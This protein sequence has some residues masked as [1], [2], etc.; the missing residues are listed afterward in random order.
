MKHKKKSGFFTFLC[1]FLPGAAEMYMGFMKTGLSLIFLFFA[2][3]ALP[4]LFGGS[5]IFLGLAFIVWIFSFFHARNLWALSDEDFAEMTDDYVWS[6]CDIARNLS[7][8]Q[9]TARKWAAWF[10]I[11]SG[12]SL[13]W[14]N[15]KGIMS[16]I[17]P[18]R[19]YGMI[20]PLIN[21]VPGIV[22]SVLVILLGIK[23]IMGKKEQL[24]IEE[25]KAEE[26]T[27]GQ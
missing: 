6:G 3:I 16:R 17:I 18:D 26:K 22:L 12:A 15:L 14:N 10:L 7:L 19:I 8:P 5:D 27:D 2:S 24:R 9:G 21:R 13:L 1:S 4:A 11:L 23:L 20:A 25:K